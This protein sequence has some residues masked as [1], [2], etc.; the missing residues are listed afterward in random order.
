VRC[1]ARARRVG[2]TESIN[3]FLNFHGAD[4][5]IRKSFHSKRRLLC[6]KDMIAT[7]KST[8]RISFCCC[9]VPVIQKME[10]NHTK[11]PSYITLRILLACD[12]LVHEHAVQKSNK[13]TLEDDLPF[14]IDGTGCD[15][16]LYR[17]GVTQQRSRGDEPHCPVRS[18][19]SECF[20]CFSCGRSGAPKVRHVARFS[21]FSTR[22]SG[23]WWKLPLRVVRHVSVTHARGNA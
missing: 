16:Y 9:S 20:S 17:S 19:P 15:D 12:N 2:I 22:E 23:R 7:I 18:R 13:A 8:V 21:C 14:G 6:G 4:V 5:Y 1:R 10:P 11:V 3:F